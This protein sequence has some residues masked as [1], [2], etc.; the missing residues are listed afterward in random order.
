MRIPRVF[1]P[2]PLGSDS[3]VQLEPQPS[4]HLARVLRLRVGDPLTL[5]DGRGGEYTA[6]ITDIGRRSVAV[7]TGRHRAG[8]GAGGLA[9][10]LGVAVSRAERMDWVVQK[11]TEL[12]VTSISPLFTEYAGVRLSD[13]RADKRLRHWRQIAVSACEQ[14]GRCLLPEVHRAIA[15]DDWLA[16]TTAERRLVLHPRGGA[17]V[18]LSATPASVALLA[19]PEGGFSDAEVS[20][21]QRAG[22]TSLRLGPRILRTETAPVAGIAILQ[23]WWGD[24]RPG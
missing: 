15:L 12:G 7:K 2:Q 22:F 6:E 13:E 14:C 24:M 17:A 19:G 23:A 5:F 1:T 21:A 20:A 9:I 18:D 11:A 16:G 4:R 8:D 10:H 3:A